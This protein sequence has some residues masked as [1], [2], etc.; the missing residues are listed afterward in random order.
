MVSEVGPE[1]RSRGQVRMRLA[2]CRAGP[3][4]LASQPG[5][6][7]QRDWPSTDLS[8]QSLSLFPLPNPGETMIL[9]LGY[10]GAGPV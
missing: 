1:D 3:W 6:N 2:G 9:V 7:R 8:S 4:S 5:Y 10:R